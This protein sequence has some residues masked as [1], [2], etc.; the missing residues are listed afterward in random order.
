MADRFYNL[1][2]LYFYVSF[3]DNR[4]SVN[5]ILIKAHV[6]QFLLRLVF[7]HISFFQV[8][9]RRWSGESLNGIYLSC[10]Y[11]LECQKKLRLTLK[12]EKGSLNL[13]GS[14][15]LQA[16]LFSTHVGLRNVL[17]L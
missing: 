3:S 17:P 1:W 8:Y 5:W 11:F 7:Q 13:I 14:S 12:S 4:R 10:L 2:S 15:E 6:I 16:P 9:M